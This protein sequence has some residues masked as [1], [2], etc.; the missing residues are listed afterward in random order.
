[1]PTTTT[2]QH[3]TDASYEAGIRYAKQH[4]EADEHAVTYQAGF[5]DDEDAF[6]D[7]FYDTVHG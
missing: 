4:P 3:P 1:M 7:G 2:T 6:I 5:H